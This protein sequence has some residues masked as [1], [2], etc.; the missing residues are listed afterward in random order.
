VTK[1]RTRAAVFLDRDGTLIR[2]VNFL[3]RAEQVE[4]IA[5]A[6]AAVRR[7]NEAGMPAIVITNQ[8]GI[9][10]GYFTQA[11][12]ETVHAR[13]VELLKA[14]GARVDAAY[15]CP[16]FPDVSGPC[17]C[18]KP[19][20]LLYRRAADEH[21]LDAKASWFIGDRLRDVSPAEELGGTGI[22]VPSDQTPLA[23]LERARKEFIV[24]ASL[25]AAVAR[26]IVSAR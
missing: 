20:T 22:L 1:G 26:A 18:R 14:D 5:G 9:A 6:A 15:V 3:A 4:L 7:I 25:D 24:E 10:R 21:G 13:M 19:G 23:E 16:H 12:Y 17:E 8:S 11:D 2:D